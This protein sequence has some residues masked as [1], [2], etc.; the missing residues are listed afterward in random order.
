MNNLLFLELVLRRCWF[1]CPPRKKQA[2]E[3][4]HSFSFKSITNSVNFLGFCLKI[5][6]FF[7][8][9]TKKKKSFKLW[10]IEKGEMKT[11]FLLPS[12]VSFAD[13]ICVVFGFFFFWCDMIFFFPTVGRMKLLEFIQRNIHWDILSFIT[14]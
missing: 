14:T 6:Y 2:S 10:E 11:Y 7:K 8:K 3:I 12:T 9:T 13:E 5:L 4:L 1:L